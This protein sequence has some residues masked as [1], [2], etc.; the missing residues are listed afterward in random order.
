MHAK[1]SLPVV[2]VCSTLLIGAA[3]TH[4]P[5]N[6]PTRTIDGP[7]QTAF[8]AQ[9]CTWAETSG[10]TVVAIGATIPMAA[11]DNAPAEQPMVWP[12][13]AAAV[14]QMPAAARRATGI[15][16]FTF[17]WEP[18]GHPPAP[19]L[20]PHFD[21]HFYSIGD[22]ARRAIDCKDL[23]K[24]A[25]LPAGYTLPDIAVPNMGTLVGLCVPEMG[26]H[27]I[28]T[29][30]M[31][32]TTAFTGS[33]IV[34][35][36]ATHPIFF[37]PMISRAKLQQRRSFT[38]SFPTPAGLKTGVHYPTKFEAIYEPAMPGYRFRFSGFTK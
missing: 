4:G 31:H 8:G 28:E 32:D 23:D 15:D 22:S 13:V 11:I 10:S 36:Y 9:I 24:P 17:Y 16:E 5:T 3:V 37:E 30:F 1:T 21:F 2:A 14:L 38:Y 25:A 6:P 26:M 12:P 34:G 27:A 35:Y 19:Y 29:V 7:C 18:D 33:M 20:T